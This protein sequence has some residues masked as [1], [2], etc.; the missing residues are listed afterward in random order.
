MRAKAKTRREFSEETRQLIKERDGGCI[1]CKM[2]YMVDDECGYYLQVM[3][4]VGRA[5]GGLG[6]ERNGAWGCA[7][8]HAMLDNSGKHKQMKKMFAEYLKGLYPD[9]DPKELKDN[10]WKGFAIS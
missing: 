2:G 7:K 10:K 4:Y 1:F 9:W 6:V 5:Q 3:H 8:H